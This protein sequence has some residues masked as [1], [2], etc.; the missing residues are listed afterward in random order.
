MI[1]STPLEHHNLTHNIMLI[2]Y[3]C[4]TDLALLRHLWMSCLINAIDHDRAAEMLQD[5]G[6]Q[7]HVR[8]VGK[9]R[10]RL[11]NAL[12]EAMEQYL[13]RDGQLDTTD[14]FKP[15]GLGL[16]RPRLVSGATDGQILAECIAMDTA[17]LESYN[18]AI[19]RSYGKSLDNLLAA[20]RKIIA[21]SV[22]GTRYFE[23]H[24]RWG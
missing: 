22:E 11:T 24:A 9:Q 1:E 15:Q 3:E 12:R 20:Q 16:R 18:T 23:N 13:R 17:L 21:N 4:L 2:N 19:T 5:R 6:L 14:T 10:Y 8:I 7:L